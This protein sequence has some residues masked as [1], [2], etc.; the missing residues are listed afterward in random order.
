MRKA[1][2][3][4]HHDENREKQCTAKEQCSSSSWITVGDGFRG[5]A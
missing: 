2:S 1:P 5:A 4:E 3:S